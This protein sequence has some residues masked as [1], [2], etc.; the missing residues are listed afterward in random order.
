MAEHLMNTYKPLP[1]TFEHGEGAYLFDSAGERYLDALCGIAVCGLGHAHPAVSEAICNQARRLLHTSNLYHIELQHKLADALCRVAAMDRVFFSN[2]GA[3]ANEAALKLARLHGHQKGISAPQ[4]IVMEGSFHGRTMATLTA[5]GNRKIQAGFEPLVPG[6]LRAPYDDLEALRTIADNSP[7]VVAILVEPITGE[8]GIRIPA[9]N[10]LT[11]IRALCDQRGWLMMLDEIQ[12]GMGRTGRWFAHQHHGVIPDVMTLAKGLGNGVP[13][14]ACL[15]RGQAAEVFRPGN[16]GSTFGGNP[17]AA[18]AALAVIE[19]LEQDQ[20][21]DNAGAMG[22]LMLQAFRE[23]LGTAPGVVSIRGQGL[24]IGIE[25]DRPCAELM[26]QALARKLLINV[27]ADSVVRLLPPLT[28][29]HEQAQTIV[30]TVSEL[31]E[32]FLGDPQ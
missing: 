24:M 3:E 13:I 6:F 11:E 5:T 18:S 15:A 31:I 22:T 2:S 23:R 1:V 29:T 12:T 8:G 32:T 9:E 10:Y 25:L 14:G 16:H 30:A 21:I 7:N 28:L 17:L 26:Q 27:T 19:T 20:L 4:V